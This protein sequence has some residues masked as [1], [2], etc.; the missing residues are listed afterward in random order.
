VAGPTA[1]AAGRLRN[2]LTRS[3]MMPANNNHCS[4]HN[5]QTKNH[6]HPAP[7]HS[8]ICWVTPTLSK[9]GMVILNIYNFSPLRPPIP[10]LCVVQ[11]FSYTCHARALLFRSLEAAQNSW[12]LAANGYRSLVRRAISSNFV[13]SLNFQWSEHECVSYVGGSPV[14]FFNELKH[15]QMS[16]NAKT[17]KYCSNEHGVLQTAS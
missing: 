2:Q 6:L 13:R 14:E 11:L 15:M 9:P 5:M 1:A 8:A 3:L 12:P 7:L 10:F 17:T 4:L 16:A